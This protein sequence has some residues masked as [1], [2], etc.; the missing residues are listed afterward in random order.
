MKKRAQRTG[1]NGA[2]QVKEAKDRIKQVEACIE[3]A[4]TR[5][6]LAERR[7]ELAETRTEL[8]EVRTDLAET[9]AEQAEVALQRLIQTGIDSTAQS[10]NGL[11]SEPR[12]LDQLTS[13]QREILQRIAEGMN[14][15][16][17]ADALNLSPKTV[18]YH[19]AKLMRVLDV[20][21]I[22]GLVRL[23]VRAGLVPVES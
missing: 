5:V 18:E 3:K 6:E 8:A 14:T 22:P 23:A 4:K 12:P 1:T 9:R 13:R 19:R 16:Q 7:T 15:K 17:I 21:D 20:H 11:A 10:S 2:T